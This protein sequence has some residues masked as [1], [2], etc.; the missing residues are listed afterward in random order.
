MDGQLHESFKE[1]CRARG[2][3][4][5]VREWLLCLQEAAHFAM[6]YQLHR[7]FVV[8]LIHCS[9]V[10]PH[11]VWDAT[12]HHL[13]DDLQHHLIHTLHIPQPTQEQVYDYGLYLID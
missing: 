1:A 8:I 3:L 9:P 13:C 4:Q 11:R 2:L 7:L 10:D 6:G 12:K 5:D